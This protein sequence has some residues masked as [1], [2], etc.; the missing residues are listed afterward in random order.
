MRYATAN[1]PQQ[2]YKG[3]L[4]K[5][6]RRQKQNSPTT[7]SPIKS[8]AFTNHFINSFLS[9]CNRMQPVADKLNCGCKTIVLHEFIYNKQRAIYNIHLPAYQ[10]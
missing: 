10:H 9:G 7:P 6:R 8:V 4:P 2:P 5:K 3:L 1:T